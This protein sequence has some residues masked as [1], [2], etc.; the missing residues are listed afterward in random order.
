ME[1]NGRWTAIG[2]GSWTYSCGKAGAP[3]IFTKLSE[4]KFM[5][6]EDI[7]MFCIICL[8]IFLSSSAIST[9]THRLAY[10]YP[11]IEH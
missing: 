10:V 7:G 11:E 5:L 6:D 8:V 1:V 2:L 3:G 4:F 9:A